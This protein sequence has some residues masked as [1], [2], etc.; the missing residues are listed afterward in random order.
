FLE[1]PYDPTVGLMSDSLRQKNL[2]SMEDPY[3]LGELANPELLEEEGSDSIVDWIRV[4]VRDKVDPSIML[5]SEAMLLQRDG[6]LITTEGDS[7]LTIGLSLDSAY[8]TVSHVNH[9][10]LTT[11]IPVALTDTLKLDF[12]QLETAV[13]GGKSSGKMAGDI[14]F[15]IA[16]D[17]N[18][19]GTID[20][21]DKIQLWRIQNGTSANGNST[22]ADFNLDGVIN[23]LDKNEF[24]RVN[25]GAVERNP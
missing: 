4:E 11:A 1:G 22:T 23:V 16:G 21:T 18:G 15:L 9:L 7:L 8:I 6:D 24:W 25:Y 5:A 17:A 13:F 19:D 14:R 3:G 20:E 2:F 12:S 10:S